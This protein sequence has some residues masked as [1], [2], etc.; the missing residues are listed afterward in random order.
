MDVRKARLVEKESRVTERTNVVRQHNICLMCV[1]NKSVSGV[2]TKMA[3]SHPKMTM[4]F[5][6]R[7]RRILIEAG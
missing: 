2:W 5:A 3:A 1:Y 4:G 6:R 7:R